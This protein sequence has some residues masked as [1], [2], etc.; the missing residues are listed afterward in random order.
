MVEGNLFTKYI[1]KVFWPYSSASESNKNK[2]K[3]FL[4]MHF[5]CFPTCKSTVHSG[6]THC[7][8]VKM[9]CCYC[10][11]SVLLWSELSLLM[12]WS[13]VGLIVACLLIHY[14]D[15]HIVYDLSVRAVLYF[16]L[17]YLIVLCLLDEEGLAVLPQLHVQI[18]RL[19][20]HL[21]IHLVKTRDRSVLHCLFN[22]RV[23]F[24]LSQLQNLHFSFVT[25]RSTL[26]TLITK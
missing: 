4:F 18:H 17:L 15:A 7:T 13:D 8:L 11:W 12:C 6:L 26:I 10:L 2:N 1:K 21:Y 25:E 14:T 20:I 24:S 19:S 23:S 22:L 5:T 3:N 16:V 9:S